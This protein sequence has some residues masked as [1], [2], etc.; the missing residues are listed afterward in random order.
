M[1]KISKSLIVLFLA[2][3]FGSS[4]GIFSIQAQN[5]KLILE[6]IMECDIQYTGNS[7]IAELKLTN[8]TGEILDGETYLHIDYKGICG[9]GFFDGEGIEAQFSITDNSWLDFSGWENGTTAVSGFE[10]AKDETQSELK[11]KTVSNLCPGEYIFILELKGTTDKEEYITP[12]VVI[13]GSG[14]Y[15]P[16]VFTSKLSEAA[17]AVDANKDDKIDVLD[18]NVLMINW[19]STTAGNIADFDSDGKVDIFDFN[20]LMI[21][22]VNL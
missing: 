9:D 15:T 1:N 5:D 10:I 11:I 7:C 20:L 2:F 22:W 4:F 13:G 6:V 12:P 8:N 21:H 19:G 16:P 14:Y 3:L 17:Q 18:F